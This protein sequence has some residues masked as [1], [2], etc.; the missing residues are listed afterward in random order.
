MKIFLLSAFFTIFFYA[1]VLEDQAIRGAESFRPWQIVV[2]NLTVATIM[3]R[4][5]KMNY[6]G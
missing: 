5:A 3:W 4:I 1:S 6:K 2:L